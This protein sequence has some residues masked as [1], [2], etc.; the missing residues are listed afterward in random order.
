MTEPRPPTIAFPD[1]IKG[2][3]R[4]WIEE[5]RYRLQTK[6][7]T[8]TNSYPT[9]E[10]NLVP[11]E[12]LD[13]VFARITTSKNPSLTMTLH[14]TAA[15]RSLFPHVSVKCGCKNKCETRRCNCVKAKVKC[16]QYCHSGHLDCFNLPSTVVEQTEVPPISRNNSTCSK[17]KRGELTPPSQQKNH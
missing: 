7:G 16:T 13:S 15:L 10:L 1:P 14:A 2:F 17:Q 9:S 6:Y 3:F 11:R 12:L 4:T 5:S 8:L